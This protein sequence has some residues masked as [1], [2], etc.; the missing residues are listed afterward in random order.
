MGVRLL[1][2]ALDSANKTIETLRSEL[3]S[4]DVHAAIKER[5]ELQSTV[6][7]LE[8]QLE[9]AQVSC[10]ALPHSA[11]MCQCVLTS[12]DVTAQNK[13]QASAQAAAELRSRLADMQRQAQDTVRCPLPCCAYC[14]G[15]A[16]C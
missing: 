3:S 7:R 10:H 5:L 14:R 8:A 4:L 13:E 9:T 6:A 2:M 16:H 11:A 15:L 1:Q 12:L